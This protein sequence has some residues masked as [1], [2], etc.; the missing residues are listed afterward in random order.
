LSISAIRDVRKKETASRSEA[1]RGKEEKGTRPPKGGTL[2]LKKA[3]GKK[4]L[5]LH[6]LSRKSKTTPAIRKKRGK[7]VAL[8]LLVL[9]WK[10]EKRRIPTLITTHPP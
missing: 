7:S 1:L 4:L 10:R 5:C 9:A 2:V 8:H 6:G 3:I